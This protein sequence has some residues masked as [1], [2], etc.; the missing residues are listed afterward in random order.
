MSNLPPP[1]MPTMVEVIETTGREVKP[2]KR[3]RRVIAAGT[4]A[5]VLALIVAAATSGGDPKLNRAALTPAATTNTPA[6]TAAPTTQAPTTEAPTTTA[7][8]CVN[9]AGENRNVTDTGYQHWTCR[10]GHWTLERYVSTV[11]PTTARA[12]TT[13]VPKMGTRTNPFPNST[14][15]TTDDFDFIVGPLSPFTG[16]LKKY[17]A[18]SLAE[19]HPGMALVQAEVTV[20]YTGDET[21]NHYSM[22]WSLHVVGQSNVVFDNFDPSYADDMP[23]TFLSETPE[24]LAGA[25][26]TGLVL[27][28]VTPDE[29]DLMFMW[30]GTQPQF[31]EAL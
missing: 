22:L 8:E 2:R 27:F 28:A 31:I 5:V 25:T 24:I 6:A 1:T 19:D 14:T 23:E 12:T 29:A 3:K 10:S 21:F 26:V 11:T 20:T 13:T 16:S 7:P 18:E 30:D 4:G 15:L 9:G 17:D